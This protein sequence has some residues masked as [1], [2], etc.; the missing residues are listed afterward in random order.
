MCDEVIRLIKR[1]PI[2]S[3]DGLPVLGENGSQK[4]AEIHREVFCRQLN[5]G[6]KEFYQA[7]AVDRHPEAKVELSDCWDYENE[8]L[9]DLNGIRYRILRTYR[10]GYRLELTLERAPAED[11]DA[12]V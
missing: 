11:G 1:Y 12:I 8:P 6:Q 10:T 9:A 2:V 3:A 7:H 4:F 5:I